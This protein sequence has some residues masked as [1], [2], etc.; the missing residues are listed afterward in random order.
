MATQES[1]K[2]E[3]IKKETLEAEERIR[4]HIRETPVE[5]SPHL[6]Q[7]G[8]CTVFLKL[9]NLQIT[10]SFKLRG[11]VNKIL[12]LSPQEKERGLITAS[13]GNYGAAF[14]YLLQK[15]GIKGLIYLPDYVSQAKIEILRSYGANLKFH[16]TD[17]IQ[18]E[19]FA[20]RE[21]E[22]NG[23]VY[24]PPYNDLKIIGGHG[25]V[26]IELARQL[27]E[28]D[29]VVVPVGGGGLV[30]GIAGYLKSFDREIEIIGCQPENSPVMFESI[31]AGKIVE[32][33]SKPTLSDGTAGG[34]E[35]DSITF[36]ICKNYV[37]DFILISE[38]EIKEAIKLFLDKHS[39]VIEGAAAL[40][41]ASL[42][43]KK[44][45]FGEKK[46]VLIISGARISLSQLKEI[47]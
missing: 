33:E 15:F 36:D 24:I 40:P 10:G 30:S 16:G 7:L 4:E 11:A 9:E 43:K 13:S 8:R 23:S 17:C 37:D 27:E 47:L 22:K 3:N 6:S 12:S 20:R 32:M 45:R 41:I 14:A 5:Y 34:I 18:T 38:E 39:M 19:T 1:W 42:I 21:A 29:A 46:V 31:K 26:G 35:E 2:S 25:T 28:F 44:E